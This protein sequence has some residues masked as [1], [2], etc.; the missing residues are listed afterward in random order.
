[1]LLFYVLSSFL[2]QKK[3]SFH[4]EKCIISTFL[5]IDSPVY[6]TCKLQGIHARFNTHHSFAHVYIAIGIEQIHVAYR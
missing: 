2:K 5:C 1:M 6:S 3:C 4:R